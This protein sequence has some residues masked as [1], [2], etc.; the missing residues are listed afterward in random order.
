MRI[1]IMDLFGIDQMVELPGQFAHYVFKMLFPE[2]DGYIASRP[3]NNATN[4]IG[5]PT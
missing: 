5:L 1:D 2:T 3:F 4:E